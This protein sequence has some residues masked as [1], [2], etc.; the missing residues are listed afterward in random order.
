MVNNVVTSVSIENDN[1]YSFACGVGSFPACSGVTINTANTNTIEFV[2]NNTAL[3][4]VNGAS[5]GITVKNGSLIRQTSIVQP[6]SLA[7]S[8]TAS[9]TITNVQYN[10]NG[11]PTDGRG[12]LVANTYE[13][14]GDLSTAYTLKINDTIR[15]LRYELSNRNGKFTAVNLYSGANSATPLFVY[16]CDTTGDNTCLD[17]VSFTLGTTSTLVFTDMKLRGVYQSQY[18]AI[19]NGQVKLNP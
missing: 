5:Q 6:I 3:S 7:A 16:T 17:K 13:F 10:K 4:V 8:G 19:I 14:S 11:T 2:F 1:K 12:E 15:N 9:G 18:D